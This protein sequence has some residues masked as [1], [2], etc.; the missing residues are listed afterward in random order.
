MRG[1]AQE[2]SPS[3]RGWRCHYCLG[4]LWRVVKEHRTLVLTLLETVAAAAYPGPAAS[5]Y[6]SVQKPLICTMFGLLGVTLEV[7]ELRHALRAP[8]L[9]CG[10][11][12]FSL[13]VTPLLFYVLLYRSGLVRAALSG[14]SLAA[15]AM[16]TMC[17][18]TTTNTNVMFTQQAGGDVSATA[19][20]AALGNFLGA[21]VTP[22]TTSLTLSRTTRAETNLARTFATVSEEIVAPLVGGLALQGALRV[23][24]K[25]DD[26]VERVVRPY[27]RLASFV[28]IQ[29]FLYVLFANAFAS[30]AG[31]QVTVGAFVVL[32]LFLT[33]VHLV[34]F[35]AAWALS[36]KLTTS[37]EQRVSLI[38][39]APQKTESL[40]V[41][42]LT[43]I[44]DDDDHIGVLTLPIVVYHT[45]QTIVAACA[46][47]AV[48][49][50]VLRV[51]GDDDDDVLNGRSNNNAGR[52]RSRSSAESSDYSYYGDGDAR[53][54]R[55]DHYYEHF[56]GGDNDSSGSG[57]SHHFPL[58]D[59]DDNDDDASGSGG[60]IVPNRLPP[61]TRRGMK[62]GTS[63][64]FPPL[65]PL[66]ETSLHSSYSETTS[67]D[68]GDVGR[69]LL[70]PNS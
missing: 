14:E 66:I 2:A 11:Q 5:I 40:G 45:I 6:G 26:F 16:A 65:S 17:L 57:S 10:C 8:K 31:D 24:F 37:P 12:F 20:N 13:M 51:S 25:C 64:R 38:F 43:S 61:P 34:F 35:F 32:V 29:A 55:L 62:A 52:R 67:D 1:G 4:R 30:D 33:A 3:R 68:D 7:S 70:P 53:L 60:G 21:I 23:C 9:H 22:A 54:S 44:F 47:A 39:T 18:P 48:R 28:T 56:H 41:A 27:G 36:A 42:I 58:E 50:N 59:D 49:R 63:T 15:G 19:I 46:V 69:P